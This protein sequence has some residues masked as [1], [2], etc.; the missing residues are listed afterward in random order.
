LA[1]KEADEMEES[2]LEQRET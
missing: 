1:S 2:L